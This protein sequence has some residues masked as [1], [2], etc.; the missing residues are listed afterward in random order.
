M[1]ALT[2]HA[3]TLAADA[4]ALADCAER[5]RDLTRRLRDHEAGPPW[6]HGLL[7]SH[8]SACAVACDDLTTAA[9]RMQD[10]AAV[11][12]TAVSGRPRSRRG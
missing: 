6:L 12:P 5:L 2:V 7:D 9:A 11:P 4:E 1:P 3:Q 10:L 8:L